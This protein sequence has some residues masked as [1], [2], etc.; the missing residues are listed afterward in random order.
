[1]PP[2][3]GRGL[4]DDE[5]VSPPRPDAPEGD[6][7]GTIGHM[8]RRTTPQRQ[9]GELLPQGEVLEQEVAA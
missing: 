5:R 6:P 2:D 7:E 9:G 8:Y 3:D 1:V 4:D